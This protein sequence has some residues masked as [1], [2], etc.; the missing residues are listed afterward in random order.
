MKIGYIFVNQLCKWLKLRLFKYIFY[1]NSLFFIFL[2]KVFLGR[3][4]LL[5]QKQSKLNII[6]KLDKKKEGSYRIE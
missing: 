3:T 6:S 4:Q 1:I 5:R 2:F